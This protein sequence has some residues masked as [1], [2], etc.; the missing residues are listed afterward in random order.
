MCC[1][2]VSNSVFSILFILLSR[3]IFSLAFGDLLVILICVPLHGLIY[4]YEEW[5]WEGKL[6]EILCRGSE[7]AKDIS[8]GVS[9]FTIVALATDR[10]QGIVNPLKK[11]QAR[12]KMVLVTIVVTWLLAILVATPSVVFSNV[13]STNGVKYC[14]PYG[15]YEK[16]IKTLGK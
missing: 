7:Y 15:Q 4:V 11:L 14:S 16:H 13:I 10:Y 9:I 12:S 5:P 3:Y 1:S 8:I 2:V 6:G